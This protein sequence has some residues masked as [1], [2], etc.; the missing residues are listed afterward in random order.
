M[1]TLELYH[2]RYFDSLR[3]R[4]ILARY[5]LE[6][7]AIRC[8]YC[9]YELVGPP[10]RRIVPDDALALSAAHVAGAAASRTQ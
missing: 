8:R 9:D 2:F 5:V 1:R 10:E 6:A 3:Q 7:A 4:W